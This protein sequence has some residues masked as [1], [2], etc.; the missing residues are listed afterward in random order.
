[1]F[2]YNFISWTHLLYTVYLILTDVNEHK[3]FLAVLHRTVQTCQWVAWWRDAQCS[4]GT[5]SCTWSWR[6]WLTRRTC[7]RPPCSRTATASAT[8]SR[9]ATWCAALSAVHN[10]RKKAPAWDVLNKGILKASVS[11]IRIVQ[12]GWDLHKRRFSQRR[13]SHEWVYRKSDS[14]RNRRT[15]TDCDRL[16]K[17]NIKLM[18]A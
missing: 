16:T 15:A 5:R 11:V 7:P 9:P 12:A 4:R 13:I 18:H 2:N 17:W 3:D 14:D 10:H 8:R 6:R 1:M